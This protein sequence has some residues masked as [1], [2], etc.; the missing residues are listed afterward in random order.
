[1]KRNLKYPVSAGTVVT[2]C[3]VVIIALIS[4]IVYRIVVLNTLLESSGGDFSSYGRLKGALVSLLGATAV[5]ATESALHHTH[6]L[7]SHSQSQIIKSTAPVIASA[8]AAVINLIIILILNFVYY[9]LA[10]FLTSWENHEVR[11]RKPSV[12]FNSIILLC[13]SWAPS[14]VFPLSHFA[15]TPL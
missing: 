6:P 5:Y 12:Q 8:S 7:C 4:T 1:M 15:R 14:S 3:M 10:I 13:A 9:Y 2:M 11:R